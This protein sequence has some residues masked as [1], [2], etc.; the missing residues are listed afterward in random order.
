MLAIFMG[1]IVELLAL[2]IKKELTNSSM[3]EIP[4]ERERDGIF[5]RITRT[6]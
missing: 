3:R 1:V 2:Q 4:M 5:V 6:D